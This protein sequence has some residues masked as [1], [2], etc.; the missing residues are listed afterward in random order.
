MSG[1]TG[2]LSIAQRAVSIISGLKS[3]S[4]AKN[5]L[6]RP[7]SAPKGMSFGNGKVLAATKKGLPFHHTW[8]SCAS[9]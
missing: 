7:T 2:T 5:S 1:V 9:P 8:T 4:P 6:H 3:G